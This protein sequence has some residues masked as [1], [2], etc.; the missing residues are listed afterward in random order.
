MP[1]ATVLAHDLARTGKFGGESL[2]GNDDF[3]EGIGYL[4]GEAR[5][6]ACQTHREIAIAHRLQCTQQFA[7]IDLALI[8]RLPAVAPAARRTRIFTLLDLHKVLRS[9]MNES[10]IAR[11][12]A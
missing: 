3:I 10:R 11:Q 6:I 7:Q 4:T 5:L 2:I 9:S 8:E 12:T 1:G